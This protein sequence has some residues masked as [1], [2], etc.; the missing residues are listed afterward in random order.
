ML[1][2]GEATSS[3]TGEDV[4]GSEAD[5]EAATSGSGLEISDETGAATGAAGSDASKL[6]VMAPLRVVTSA[7]SVTFVK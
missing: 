4:S 6:A 2:P 5:V 1:T 7:L 3:A